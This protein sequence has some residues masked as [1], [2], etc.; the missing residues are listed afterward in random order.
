MNFNKDNLRK[1]GQILRQSISERF[2]KEK[3]IISNLF[4]L[5]ITNKDIVAGYY[6]NKTEVNIMSY[7]EYLDTIKIQVC[8]PYIKKKDS[9]LLFRSWN[10]NTCLKNGMYNIPTPSSGILCT[11]SIL[12]IPLIAFDQ[13]KNRLGY[14]GGFYDRT[15]SFLEEKN[16]ILKIG[17]AFEE[18][19]I[20]SIPTMNY[21][22]KLDMVITQNGIIK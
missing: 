10:K 2:T 14:G 6:P 18:Q 22:K 9:Y 1:K 4:S 21:D 15:I 7:I 16:K 20:A 13:N 12:L 17:V 19:K 11:P 8:L 3:K 5:E